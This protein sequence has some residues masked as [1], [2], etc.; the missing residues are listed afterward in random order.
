MWKKLPESADLDLNPGSP[1][2][3]PL[4]SGIE[5]HL[6]AS[7]SSQEGQHVTLV[8]GPNTHHVQSHQ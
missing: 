4:N 8:Q 7:G 5:N 2:S 1:T 3:E 6:E